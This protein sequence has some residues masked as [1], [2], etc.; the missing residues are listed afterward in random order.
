MILLRKSYGT[1][2]EIVKTRKENPVPNAPP[3]KMDL[4]FNTCTQM[5]KLTI[6][7]GKDIG[8]TMSPYL[9]EML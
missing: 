5:V 6:K 1:V 9:L 8:V 4:S 7:G 3:F 2:S